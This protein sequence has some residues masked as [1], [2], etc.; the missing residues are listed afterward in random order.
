MYTTAHYLEWRGDVPFTVSPVNEVDRHLFA[1]IGKPDFTGII[2]EEG[3]DCSVKE[4]ADA[5]FASHSDEPSSL[6]LLVSPYV[7]PTLKTLAASPRYDGL[8]LSE[9]V[10]RVRPEETEQFSALTVTVPD[11]A[12]YVTFRGTDDT[13]IAWKEDFLLAVLETVPA[14]QDALDYLVRAAELHEGPIVVSGHS[15]GGNLAVYAAA[16]APESVQSRIRTVYSYDGPGFPDAFLATPGYLAI[17]D[18]V[19][20]IVPQRSTVGMLMT[21]AGQLRSV[22]TERAGIQAHDGLS[23]EVGVRSFVPQ[24]LGDSAKNFHQ[25]MDE[26]LKTTDLDGRRAIIE[27]FF[28]ILNDAGA[29]TVS[30]FTEDSLKKAVVMAKALRREKTVSTFALR[31]T[32]ELIRQYM[33]AARKGADRLVRR[34]RD[35][36]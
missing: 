19:L 20:T 5:Y 24:E 21:H 26:I 14:Q 34:D 2:P 30:D 18:R 31:L 6:G 16:M 29:E 27:D 1:V 9:F 25:A 12:I 23:W 3:G 7:L 4:A 10:N 22:R 36:T 32:E 35:N 28:D 33:Q 13:L 17:R 8:R 15:K 11:D